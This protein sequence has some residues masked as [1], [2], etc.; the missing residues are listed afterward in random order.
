MK[1]SKN[2]RNPG[3]CPLWRRLFALALAIVGLHPMDRAGAQETFIAYQVP[4]GTAGN[5][6][7]GG[8]L[9][10]D[11]DVENPVVLT[12]LGVFDDGSDGLNATLIARLWDRT[13]ET[14]VASLIFTP[15]DPGELVGGSRFKS[16]ETPLE[17][18]IGFRGTITAEGYGEEEKL[19]NRFNEDTNI[20][21]TTNDGNGS[22]RFVG[23]SRWGLVPGSYPSTVDEG[24]AARYAAGTFEFR[25]TPIVMPGRPDLTLRPGDARVEIFWNEVTS[26]LPAAVYL[27]FRRLAAAETFELIAELQT[28]HYLDTNVENGAEYCYVVR[29]RASNGRE[30]PDSPV[31]CTSP[32]RLPDNHE[33]AYFTPAA[34]G[35]QAFS[36]SL[37]LDF[38]IQS[39]IVI[40]ALGV[41]DDGADGL[42]RPLAARIFNRETQ[43]IVAEVLFAP[44]QGRL[45]EGMRFKD[46]ES[47]LR[48]EAGFKGVM[49]ADG[50][51]PGERLLNSDGNTNAIV[52]TLHDGNGSILF[53]GSSRYGFEPGT[54]PEILDQGPAARFAAGTFLYEVL[55]PERPG[56]PVLHVVVP[57]ED[58]KVTLYWD[59]IT[60]PLPAVT[61]RVF[62]AT[63]PAGP[64]ELVAETPD[65]SYEDTGLT[66]GVEVF[67]RIRAVAAEGRESLDSNVVR[68]RPNPREPGVAYLVAFGLAGSGTYSGSLGMDFDVARPV[69]ITELGVF[70]SSADGLFL[71]LTVVLYDRQTREAL[72]SLEF[73]PQDPGTLR[74]GSRF[75]ALP[76]PVVLPAGFQGV[77]A[78]WG[79]GSEEPYFD[80]SLD[81]AELQVFG[82]GSLLFVGSG[83]FGAAG[84]FPA[85][86]DRGPVN[87]YGAGTFYFE[88][89]PALPQL[90]ITRMGGRIRLTW[91]GTG[92]LESATNLEGPWTTVPDA[93][94]GMELPPEGRQ[95]FFR[96]RP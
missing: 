69:R 63:D 28:T 75:K 67:Y 18:P 3:R 23:S 60:R 29:A 19:R 44:G 62:R 9:G 27:V 71:T 81:A 30:G 88:P 31:R 4:A 2:D 73:T 45:I 82:G 52:W 65:T 76:Q 83:R 58:A 90:Q 38:D 64:F 16:L 70:D 39:P 1:P 61:Y 53:V 56:I 78:C 66:N 22:I 55:P 84:R 34:T 33:I 40:K 10:M 32:Y 20:V 49:Q 85:T 14:E 35:N 89:L 6:A 87:R 12:R 92:V 74:D 42:T 95:R 96:V 57:Y 50:Y 46:L 15:D 17:L 51:G 54:F 24:P 86:P 72:A 80:N 91:T 59:P 43:E 68:S 5:Q 47:P 11:F 94:S 13:T 77:I 36:G 37:G 93:V 26:P 41:F 79:Y 48:L 7:F 25:S 8:V 21:W